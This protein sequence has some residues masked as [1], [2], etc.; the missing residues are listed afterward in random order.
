MSL[1]KIKLEKEHFVR[2]ERD[3]R[4]SKRDQSWKETHHRERLKE[5]EEDR[6][7]ETEHRERLK[8]EEDRRSEIEHRERLKREEE[9]GWLAYEYRMN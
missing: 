6:R 3:E 1:E 2:A 7:S 8:K 9:D 4:F 5:E